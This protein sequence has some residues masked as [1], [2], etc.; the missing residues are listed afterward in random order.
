MSCGPYL[1]QGKHIR[2]RGSWLH[3]APELVRK[4]AF[5]SS[6]FPCV[7]PEPVLTKYRIHRDV[8]LNK[9]FRLPKETPLFFEFSLCLSRACLGKMMHFMYKW[10]KKWRFFTCR[11]SKLPQ[12]MWIDRAAAQKEEEEEEEEGTDGSVGI[13]GS[14]LL[15]AP[16][17]KAVP[18]Q[19]DGHGGS[20]CS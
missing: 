2:F 3:G 9:A 15:R 10:R 16:V 11:T 14:L 12:T 6:S 1:L 8:T 5:L 17:R 4:T 7:C 13:I 20:A 19:S 18:G